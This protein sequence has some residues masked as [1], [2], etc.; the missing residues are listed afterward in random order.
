MKAELNILPTV[1]F[2]VLYTRTHDKFMLGVISRKHFVS[3]DKDVRFLLAGNKNRL[4]TG[5]HFCFS[6][7]V[8]I[9]SFITL[10]TPCSQINSGA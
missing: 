7:R 4:L 10:L 9:P 3:A 6:S 5:F 8:G 2:G 1:S